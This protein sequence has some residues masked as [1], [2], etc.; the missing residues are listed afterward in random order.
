MSRE[1]DKEEG[2]QSPSEDIRGYQGPAEATRDHQRPPGELLTED[3]VGKSY[4]SSPEDSTAP[5]SAQGRSLQG[6]G[7]MVS[8]ASE[9]VN[10]YR[11]ND[12][13]GERMAEGWA[14]GPR[15]VLRW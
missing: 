10:L 6:P 11:V 7:S 3:Y 1:K 9:E 8:R 14:R 4:I 13:H 15:G 12:H 5:R 2:S